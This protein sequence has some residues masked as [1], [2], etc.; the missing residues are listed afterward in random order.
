MKSDL[1]NLVTAEE[2]FFSVDED[3]PS[4]TGKIDYVDTFIPGGTTPSSS[5]VTYHLK[6]NK[7]S[8]QQVMNFFKLWLLCASPTNDE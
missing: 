2:A 4:L 7:L 8:K 5:K 6:A 3:L 1:R